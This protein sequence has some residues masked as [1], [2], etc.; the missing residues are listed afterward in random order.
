MLDVLE[1]FGVIA[2]VIFAGLMLGRSGVLGPTGQQVL[3]RVVFYVATPALL[4]VTISS[5]DIGAIFSPALLATGGSAVLVF[6]GIFA[7]TL[8]SR[9]RSLGE[10]TISAMASGYVNIGNLGI[11]IATYVLKDLSFVAPVLL[12]QLILLSP[13]IMVLLDST[14][15][16]TGSEWW[17][18][19]LMVLRNPIV[20]G[21]ALGVAGSLTGWRLPEVVHEPVSMLAAM[22]V[23]GMLL[24]FGISLKDGWKLPPAGSRRQL[25]IITVTKL[26]IQPFIAWLIGGVLL[27]YDGLMLMGIV[28]TSTLPTAQ[29]VYIYAMEYKASAQL[30]RDAVFITTIL[31]VPA[32]V[33]AA[34]LFGV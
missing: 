2:V 22:S 10:A 20:I 16:E 15:A 13:I 14:R 8:W 7:F 24:A 31:S 26:V 25:V 27:G 4:Y 1:G 11:P 5:T 12:F 32:V 34:L 21:A 29:N 30:A 18:P 19:L 17:R 23:P 6:T 9:R 3:A 28:V 33:V